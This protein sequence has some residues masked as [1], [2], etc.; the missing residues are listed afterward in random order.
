MRMPSLLA[1]SMLISIRSVPGSVKMQRVVNTHLC[2][3]G[4]FIKQLKQDCVRSIVDVIYYPSITHSKNTSRW[5][6]GHFKPNNRSAPRDVAGSH[7][8]PYGC[9]TTYRNQGVGS[10]PRVQPNPLRTMQKTWGNAGSKHTPQRSLRRYCMWRERVNEPR[11][12]KSAV[13]AHRIYHPDINMA[14]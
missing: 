6:G 2:H 13:V 12:N 5:S 7:L 11:F 8:Q 9:I 10:E 14:K 3:G 4:W 1:W